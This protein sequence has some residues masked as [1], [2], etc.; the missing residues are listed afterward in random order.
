MNISQ[1]AA[2]C[3]LSAK[4]IRDYERAGLIHPLRQVNGYRHYSEHDLATLCFIRHAREVNFSLTQIAQLLQLR[5][6]PNRASA[7]VKTLVGEHIAVL[8]QKIDQ[9]TA[10]KTT[11]QQWHQQ[12][13]GNDHAECAIINHLNQ[14]G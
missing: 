13:L 3:G 7:D 11:L 2:R 10:M 4:S 9:L 12:C 14:C 1:V 5:N 6:N 8:S